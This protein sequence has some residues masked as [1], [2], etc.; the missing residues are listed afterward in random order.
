MQK[1]IYIPVPVEPRFVHEGAGRR[2]ALEAA[3]LESVERAAVLEGMSD[4]EKK[5]RRYK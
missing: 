5:R 4:N 2:A 3:W 1:I